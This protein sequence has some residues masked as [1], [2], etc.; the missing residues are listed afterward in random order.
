MTTVWQRIGLYWGA[1]FLAAVLGS[2][3]EF[4]NDTLSEAFSDGGPRGLLA[5]GPALLIL[6]MGRA[7]GPVAVAVAALAAGLTYWL[8]DTAAEAHPSDGL[9]VVTGWTLGVLL[10]TLL[11]VALNRHFGAPPQNSRWD[12]P[13]PPPT[14]AA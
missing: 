2:Y 3:G 12:V 14:N 7:S 13:P 9:T 10:A 1:C 11:I 8:C 4:G 5:A 6:V